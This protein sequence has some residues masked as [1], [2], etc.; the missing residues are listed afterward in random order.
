M[1]YVFTGPGK[2]KTSAALGMAYRASGYGHRV[3]VVQFFKNKGVGEF[4]RAATDKRVNIHQFGSSE[5][6][7]F[8]DPREEDRRYLAEGLDKVQELIAVEPFLIV[9]DE[10]NLALDYQM[11][12]FEEFK[13][14]LTTGFGRIHFVLTGRGAP[15]ELVAWADLVTEFREVK[16]PYGQGHEAIEGLDF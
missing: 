12:S 14:L 11:I 3:E 9:L 4:Q 10:I 15:D 13:K 16:H 2:G 1:I 8:S 5:W 6:V 7:D